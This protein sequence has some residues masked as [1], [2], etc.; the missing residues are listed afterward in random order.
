MRREEQ[1]ASDLS[2]LVTAV[3]QGVEQ[4]KTAKKWRELQMFDLLFFANWKNQAI[5]Q[6]LQA[7]EAIDGRLFFLVACECGR[8]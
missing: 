8:L 6:V 4:F 7:E 5:V 2:L 1:D 3:S